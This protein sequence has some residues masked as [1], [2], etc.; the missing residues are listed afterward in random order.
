[1]RIDGRI[2]LHG[3][4]LRTRPL[5]GPPALGE[6]PEACEV[7]CRRYECQVCGAVLVVGP[8]GIAYGYLYS[9]MAIGLALLAWGM[10]RQREEDVH[11]ALS[12]RRVRGPSRPSRWQTVRRW[13]KAAAAG[14][15]WSSVQAP[16][17]PARE[18][19]ERV[20]RILCAR[21]GPARADMERIWSASSHAR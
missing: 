20:A 14:S 18:Q 1:M 5:L 10:L 6:Q 17:G 4:G 16:S 8:R 19:A 7:V 15:I 13:A 9:A 3:H 21:A 12:V 11:H 2:N